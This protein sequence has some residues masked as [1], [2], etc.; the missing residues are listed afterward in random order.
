MIYHL[1]LFD[2]MIYST[3]FIHPFGQ[4]NLVFST[5]MSDAGN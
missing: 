1:K 4:I 3:P 5:P 2:H